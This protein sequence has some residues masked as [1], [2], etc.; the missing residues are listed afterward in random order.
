MS[1]VPNV[2]THAWLDRV[3]DIFWICVGAVGD[4]LRALTGVD[5]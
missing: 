2:R 1:R 3:V 5:E 4:V